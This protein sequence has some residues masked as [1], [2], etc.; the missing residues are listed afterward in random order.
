MCV[1]NWPFADAVLK[2]ASAPF[3]GLMA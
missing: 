1:V 3:A 2:K